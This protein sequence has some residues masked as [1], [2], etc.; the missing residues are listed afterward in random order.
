MTQD[1]V[2]I[3]TLSPEEVRSCKFTPEPP[4]GLNQARAIWLDAARCIAMIPIM[5]LHVRNQPNFLDTPVG[6]A[7]CLFFLLA[8]YFL[9][10]EPSKC[11]RRTLELGLA[12]LLWSL[13]SAGFYVL[14]GQAWRWEQFIGWQMPAYNGP[15]WFLRNLV[16]FQLI[17]TA[18][19][20]IKALP[21]YC[22]LWAILLP[23]CA[24][25]DE[26][27][28]HITLNF[29]WMMALSLGFALGSISLQRISNFLRLHSIAL[30]ILC[31]CVLI[32][33]HLWGWG[34]GLLDWSFYKSNLPLQSLAYALIYCLLALVFESHIYAFTSML[35]KAGRNMMFIYAAHIL[36]Y[37][38][39]IGVE[40]VF[41][42]NIPHDGL[43]L[44]L[45]TIPLLAWLCGLLQRYIPRVMTLLGCRP[46][47]LTS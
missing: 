43:W 33:P 19:M 7:I 31:L 44:A 28:Q 5:W 29:S 46:S 18:L 15:L 12:W 16:I 25:S 4:K 24:F 35:A 21:R 2:Q 30:G 3:A 39:W 22:W 38:L 6:G 41:L 1:S 42:D 14:C 10:R 9:P 11:L 27:P 32:Q 36:I 47:K 34:C 37:S 26:Y 40:I 8:G 45:L 13:I 20:Y 17:L 23:C